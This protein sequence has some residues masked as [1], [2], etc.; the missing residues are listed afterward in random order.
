[1]HVD[2]GLLVIRSYHS[3]TR[4]GE[5][6]RGGT[7]RGVIRPDGLLNEFGPSEGV[8]ELPSGVKALILY[9]ASELELLQLVLAAYRRERAI[10]GDPAISH[11]GLHV[12][13][14]RLEDA[15]QHL[16]KTFLRGSGGDGR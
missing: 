3:F 12:D 14:G 4:E 1:M 15:V 6:E 13:I 11:G 7:Y 2:D 8:L 16:R 10:H 9:D 5:F